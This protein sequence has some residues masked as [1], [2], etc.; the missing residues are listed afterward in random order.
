MINANELPTTFR[1]QTEQYTSQRTLAWPGPSACSGPS[2]SSCLRR[3]S[4]SPARWGLCGRAP[5]SQTSTPSCTTWADR[6][7]CGA[8][9]SSLW[10]PVLTPHRSERMTSTLSLSQDTP[11][12][13]CSLTGGRWS[14]LLEVVPWCLLWGSLITPMT[15]MA[16]G[17]ERDGIQSKTYFIC[18]KHYYPAK[19]DFLPTGCVLCCTD[20]DV[21][22]TRNRLTFIFNLHSIWKITYIHDEVLISNQL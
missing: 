2:P 19:P 17:V 1:L 7:L 13:P 15:R 22:L 16:H 9:S 11:P 20:L 3:S 21:A 4:L 8:G 18:K 12:F 14:H 6:S 10:E 5:A